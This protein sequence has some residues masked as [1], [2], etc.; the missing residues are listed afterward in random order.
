MLNIKI[1]KKHSCYNT[2]F[3]NKSVIHDT[4][5]RHNDNNQDKSDYDLVLQYTSIEP[6]L[7]VNKNDVDTFLKYF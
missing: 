3:K 2:S 5:D 1:N 7:N 4:T 6:S